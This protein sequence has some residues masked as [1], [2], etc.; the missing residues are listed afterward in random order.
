MPAD[1]ISPNKGNQI[2]ISKL[3]EE[4]SSAQMHYSV[5]V[6]NIRTIT[7][8][9]GFVILSGIGYL[10]NEEQFLLSFVAGLFGLALTLILYLLYRH[11]LNLALAALEYVRYLEKE[12]TSPKDGIWETI[13]KKREEFFSNK[14][15]KFVINKLLYYLLWTTISVIMIFGAFYYFK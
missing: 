2:G 11:Y 10:I 15:I 8:A 4:A 14:L 7:I 6:R 3:Y 13:G 12:Y 9:Q 1:K 5:S